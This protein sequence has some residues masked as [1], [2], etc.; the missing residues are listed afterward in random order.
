MQI[1]CGDNPYEQSGQKQLEENAQGFVRQNN[2]LEDKGEIMQ[3]YW[4]P[5]VLYR[6]EP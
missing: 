2:Q 4:I 3:D 5:A 6:A 1:V